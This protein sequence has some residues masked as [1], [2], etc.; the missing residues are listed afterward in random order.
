M[1]SLT[2]ESLQNYTHDTDFHGGGLYLKI[3][4]G[5]R[6]MIFFKFFSNQNFNCLPFSFPTGLEVVRPAKTGAIYRHNLPKNYLLL[7]F[8]NFCPF[9]KKSERRANAPFTLWSVRHSSVGLFFKHLK[10]IKIKIFLIKVFCMGALLHNGLLIAEAFEFK[11]F[12]GSKVVFVKNILRFIFTF[13]QFA[14][15]FKNANVNLVLIN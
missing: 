1:A 11:N 13:L 6:Q 2:G 9:L 8:F 15:V 10:T 12:C 14:F 5:C 7:V 4:C 3:G